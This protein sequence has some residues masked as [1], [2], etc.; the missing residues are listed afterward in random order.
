VRLYALLLALP[1]AATPAPGQDAPVFRADV[2]LVHVDAE[3]V[4]ADGRTVTGLVKDDFRVLDNRQPQAIVHFSAEEEPLDLILLF[5]ISGSM[6]TAVRKVAAAAKTGLHELR[7]GDRVAVMVFNAR[8]REIAPFTEDLDAVDRTLRDD[9]LTLRFGGG[10]LIQKAA[11][12]AA[13][14]FRRE[15]KTRR[16]RAVLIVT[17]N[18]GTRTRRESAVVEDFWESDAILSGL[19]VSNPVFQAARILSPLALASQAGMKGIARKTGGDAIN[20]DDPGTD[21]QEAMRRIRRRY[22]LYYAMPEAKPGMARAIQVELAGDAAARYP[23]ARVRARTGYV[24]PGA[25]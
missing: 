22:S 13:L 12:T 17:D 3:V 24:V 14:R 2:S 11:D 4:A 20:A 21:F 1:V 6:R 8:T 18:M 16:R 15:P 5:D 10:T 9:V 25:R 23:K 7:E 19:I